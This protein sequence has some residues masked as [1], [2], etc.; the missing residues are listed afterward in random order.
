MSAMKDG[1]AE[2]PLVSAPCAVSELKVQYADSAEFLSKVGH[3]MEHFQLMR[4]T[5]PDGNCFYR[6]YLFAVLEQVA[7][8]KERHAALMDRMKGA[9]ED[10]AE[11]GYEK[12]AIDVFYDDFMDVMT[13][14]GTEGASGSTV[15]ALWEENDKCLVCWARILTSAHLKRHEQDFACFLTSHPSIQQFCAQEVDPMNTEA[16]HL[17]ISALSSYLAVPVTVVYLDRTEGAAAEHPFA[18][19]PSSPFEPVH[20][21]YRPGHYDLVYRGERGPAAKRPPSEMESAEEKE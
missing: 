10:C 16:D 12:V 13:A 21:L 14:L 1:K 3:L 15:Q 2:L 8:H 19:D 7:G 20:L 9:L 5:Q 17:Q 18:H 4:R 6:A 11:A